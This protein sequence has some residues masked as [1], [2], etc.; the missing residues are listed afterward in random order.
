M[1]AKALLSKYIESSQKVFNEI[2][3]SQSAKVAGSDKV[4]EVVDYAKRY[5]SDAEYYGEKQQYATG[6]TS[7]AYCEGLLD[8]LR[9]LGLVTFTW[10]E[11]KKET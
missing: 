9:L 6:L 5:L 10:P 4:A 3:L 8:A 2:K 1:N 11:V 7:V